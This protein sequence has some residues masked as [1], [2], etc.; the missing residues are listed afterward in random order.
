MNTKDINTAFISKLKSVINGSPI[1][2]LVDILPLSKEAI[3]RRLRGE[4]Q[5]SY[6]E[7]VLIAR[8][9]Q[10]SLDELVFGDDD[11]VRFNYLAS[12]GSTPSEIYANTL[13]TSI[14]VF[15]LYEN[16]ADT[17]LYMVSTNIPLFFIAP[18]E[19]LFRFYYYE[20]IHSRAGADT[21]NKKYRYIQVPTEIKENLKI[22]VDRF[23]SIGTTLMLS[24]NMFEHYLNTLRYFTSVNLIS[25]SEAELIIKDLYN[26]IDQMES[27]T[28]KGTLDN[29]SQMNVYLVE[30][31]I[32][33]F[34]GYIQ[35]Q[36][37]EIAFARV[38][39]FSYAIS[40]SP[41]VCRSYE[42]SIN[43]LKKYTSLISQS[44]SILRTEYFNKQR[45][46]IKDKIN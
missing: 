1:D 2:I 4:V 46:L 26:I 32:D 3:Y 43:R 11:D 6:P 36:T 9:L 20:F 19:N 23:S 39:P 10:F 31:N 14:H 12:Q 24:V 21:I 22:Y 30:G 45:Q 38:L 29:G 37:K 18:Y 41:N 44:G 42:E 7:V 5:F 34:W 8:Q 16:S 33:S 40:Y 13:K 17:H 27:I 25:K 35:N 15:N 28:T